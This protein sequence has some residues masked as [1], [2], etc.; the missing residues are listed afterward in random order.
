MA[1]TVK[2]QLD[3]TTVRRDF[4]GEPSQVYENASSAAWIVTQISTG[5][6][7]TIF[8]VDNN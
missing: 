2:L 3:T 6:A 4:A 1:V 5:N 8:R 7:L